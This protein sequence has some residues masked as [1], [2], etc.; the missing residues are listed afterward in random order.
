MS[1]TAVSPTPRRTQAERS[2]STRARLM[3]ATTAVLVEKGYAG[4]TIAEIETRAGVSRGARLHHFPSKAALLAAAVGHIYSRET[5]KY[6]QAMDQ[7]GESERD[8]RAGY[9]LLWQ[10]YSDPAHAAV[11][12]IYVAART[13]PEL[14]A[15][16]REISRGFESARQN[17]NQ[18]FPDL[19]TREARGLLECIQASML[20]LSLRRMVHGDNVGG[21]RALDQLER[22]VVQQFLDSSLD[23]SKD[24]SQNRSEDLA[25]KPREKEPRHE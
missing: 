18:L 1:A 2:A 23:P 5:R 19:A 20:G 3:D 15:A 22:M 8:F 7:M 17:A 21:D 6:A 25:A 16:L 10:T 12:E 11:L 13:D 24:P 4:A 9:R 14:R